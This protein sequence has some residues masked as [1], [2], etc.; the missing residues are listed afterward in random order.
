MFS[1]LV[2]HLAGTQTD[3]FKT[4]AWNFTLLILASYSFR[5]SPLL[6]LSGFS[7]LWPFLVSLA[8]SCPF[9][10][11]SLLLF[12]RLAEKFL[13]AAVRL[14]GHSNLIS[15][16]LMCEREREREVLIN[17]SFGGKICYKSVGLYSIM[18]L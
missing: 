13:C 4:R 2:W 9:A 17:V 7:S 18:F 6:P 1:I 10:V 11:L 3:S 14:A 12:G 8:V 16:V 15:C 5:D